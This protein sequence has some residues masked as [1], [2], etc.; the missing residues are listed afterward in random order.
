MN[1][2]IDLTKTRV[3][4]YIEVP[5]EKVWWS[6]ST[7]DGS[8]TYLTDAG[9]TTGDREDPKVGDQYTLF[10]GDIINLTVI[11]HFEPHKKFTISDSYK[12][13][14]PNG[15]IETYDI[16]TT[17]YLTETENGVRL[18][19]EVEGF[20]EGTNGQWLK[21]C[22]NMGWRRSLM[23]LK[24]V[25]E[26]GLDLRLELFSFPRLGVSNCTVQHCQTE[27]TGVSV[28]AGNYL[29]EVFPNSPADKAGLKQGDVVIAFDDK[30]VPTYSDFV[31]VISSY[32]GKN[33]PV[34]ISYIRKGEKLETIVNFSLDSI[35]TGIIKGD[36]ESQ[37]ME[38]EKRERLAYQRSASGEVWKE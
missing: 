22:L 10:Y 37:Q 33:D 38:K 5:I 18:V 25:L 30:P 24:S 19:L 15:R 34:N 21:E 29:L 9:E 11:K 17:F 14:A 8:N 20:S 4:T 1:N 23:N 12:S 31:R 6:V 16:M 35:F 28:G 32:Y 3:E 7:V 26:L 27:S 36:R 13:M 2:N